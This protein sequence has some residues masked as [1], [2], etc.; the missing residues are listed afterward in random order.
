MDRQTA[1]NVIVQRMF[2]AFHADLRSKRA[3]L[4]ELTTRE[5]VNIAALKTFFTEEEM[6][7][8][9]DQLT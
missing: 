8:A 4:A 6:T 5:L 7:V 2:E 3:P 9:T 1:I